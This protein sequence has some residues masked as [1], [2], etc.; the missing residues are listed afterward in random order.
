MVV[1]GHRIS[2]GSHICSPSAE[3]IP[4]Y[5]KPSLQSSYPPSDEG[6]LPHSSRMGTPAGLAAVPL[7]EQRCA[8]SRGPCST[9]IRSPRRPPSNRR[10]PASRPPRSDRGPGSPRAWP[11]GMRPSRRRGYSFIPR[12]TMPSRRSWRRALSSCESE[13]PSR[14]RRTSVPWSQQRHSRRL[15]SSSTRA[16]PKF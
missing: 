5:S 3:K 11:R 15:D 12:F 1:F 4:R 8:C 6:L 16:A 2:S 7:I 9:M 10:R 14:W 13:I